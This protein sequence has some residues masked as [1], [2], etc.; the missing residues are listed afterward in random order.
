MFKFILFL[1]S[2]SKTNK[3]QFFLIICLSCFVI[4]SEVV[5]LYVFSELVKSGGVLQILIFGV[6]IS[7]SHI[8][9]A[10]IFGLIVLVYAQYRISFFANSIGQMIG[11]EILTGYLSSVQRD[12]VD[13]SSATILNSIIVEGNRVALKIV[14]PLLDILSRGLLVASLLGFA[15]FENPKLTTTFI[16]TTFLIYIFFL[17][18][19]SKPLKSMSS[20]FTRENKVRINHIQEAIANSTE[21]KLYSKHLFMLDKFSKSGDF[22]ARTLSKI[23]IISL[24][25]KLFIEYGIIGSIAV[26]YAIDSNFLT[27]LLV[28]SAALLLAFMKFLPSAHQ[29]YSSVS[30]LRGNWSSIYTIVELLNSSNSTISKSPLP[31]PWKEL[32]F[33]DIRKTFE[34]NDDLEATQLNAWSLTLQDHGLYG[35]FGPSGSGKSTAVGI[36]CGLIEP[37]D[38]NIRLDN[39]K[40]KLFSNRNWLDQVSFVQ[41]TPSLLGSTIKENVVFSKTEEEIDLGK[42]RDC[43]TRSGINL[44]VEGL[45]LDQNV[46]ERGN[47]LSGG[48]RQRIALARALYAERPIIIMDEPTSALDGKSELEMIKTVQEM[49]STHCVIVISHSLVVQQSLNFD[50]ILELS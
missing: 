42:V 10:S 1:N 49:R 6:S 39:K 22:I 34:N 50:V 40:V 48:Q 29:V 9:L 27:G 37:D 18:F 41:Q 14:K 43:L 32:H 19:S 38:G 28:N 15:F 20:G 17:I 35:I 7:L 11:D 2:L 44:K 8:I 33:K 21:I 5:L 16:L 31:T 4:V 30:V 47:L 46:G 25:P 23:H 13:L 24:S 36:I 12:N 45:H 3:Y 26:F